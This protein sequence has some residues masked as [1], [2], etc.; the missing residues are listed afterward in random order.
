MSSGKELLAVML[1]REDVA[2]L[3]FDGFQAQYT[4]AN[5]EKACRRALKPEPPSRELLSDAYRG[6]MKE[7][8]AEALGEWVEYV[9]EY[10]W[11]AE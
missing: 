5:V 10:G 1:P 3:A 8:Q 7:E 6:R 4:E 9:L 11:E 2:A